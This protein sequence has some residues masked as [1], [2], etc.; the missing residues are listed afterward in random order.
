V[1][2]S[3]PIRVDSGYGGPDGDVGA[4]GALMGRT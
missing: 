1:R 3:Y 2:A 4:E